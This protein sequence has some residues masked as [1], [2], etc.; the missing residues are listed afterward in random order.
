MYLNPMNEE[1]KRE[2]NTL[3]RQKVRNMESI[4]SGSGFS[5][6]YSRR[7]GMGRK[8]LQGEGILS[9]IAGLAEGF[10]GFG[11]QGQMKYKKQSEKVYGCGSSGGSGFR[12]GTHMDTGFDRTIGAGYSGGM[13]QSYHILSPED[14]EKLMYAFFGKGKG[15]KMRDALEGAGFWSDFAD[16]FKKGF[17]GTLDV[18]TKALPVV[19]PFIGLGKS[20][21][22]KTTM[23][24]LEQMGKYVPDKVVEKSQMLGSDM[25][26]FGRRK[27]KVGEGFQGLPKKSYT[28]KELGYA[29]P[30]FPVEGEGFSG[31]RRTESE[32]DFSGG[33]AGM[34][35]SGGKKKAPNAW[36]QLV[37]K[38]RKEKG[39]KGIKEAI[40]YIKEKGLYKK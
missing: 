37:N 34:G 33:F 38:V 32:G 20:G 11:K 8:K 27:K 9:D 6:G 39:F 31:G 4:D 18:A 16:G 25:S 13:K 3:N 10:L 2:V 19:A 29:P 21:G 40:Q 35:S 24:D 7:I 17:L 36:I 23:K 12:K 22:K 30:F 26:G 1:I 28:Y 15:K 14:Q 5:G